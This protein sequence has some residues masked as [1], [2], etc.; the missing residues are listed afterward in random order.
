MFRA[1]ASDGPVCYYFGMPGTVYE[2]LG[3]AEAVQLDLSKDSK[4][5]QQE[6]EKFATTYFSQFKKTR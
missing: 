6:M 2:N 4:Q 5:A 1:G 3:H